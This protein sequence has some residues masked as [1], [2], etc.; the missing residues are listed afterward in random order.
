MV[1]DGTRKVSVG[2]YVMCLVVAVVFSLDSYGQAEEGIS[3]YVTQS[4]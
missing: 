4:N 2:G 3:M 1:W